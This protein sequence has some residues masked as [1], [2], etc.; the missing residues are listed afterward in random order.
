LHSRED[1]RIKLYVSAR[2]LRFRGEHPE[3]FAGRY[4][5]IDVVGPRAGHVFCFARLAGDSS[6]L[7][8]V[9]RLLATLMES[10]E[11][12]PLGPQ[13]WAETALMLPPQL[14]AGRWAN[15]FTGE[16]FDTPP[17]RALP[18]AQV[19]GPFPVALCDGRR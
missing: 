18:V 12:P 14:P 19:L 9:P 17:D 2:A 6:A 16:S 11:R 7:V 3:L 10:D 8:L 1:G 13:I 15:A 4:L 5:P